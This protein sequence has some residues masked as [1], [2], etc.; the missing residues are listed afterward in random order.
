MSQSLD[1]QEIVENGALVC[2]ENS[3]GQQV[4]GK[5]TFES[6]RQ[7]FMIVWNNTTYRVSQETSVGTGRNKPRITYRPA[8]GACYDPKGNTE[9][10][11]EEAKES[12]V[13]C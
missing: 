9:V 4:I 6:S 1:I 11:I 10:Q 5:K 8:E 3:K 13:S 12:M 2:F 7:I